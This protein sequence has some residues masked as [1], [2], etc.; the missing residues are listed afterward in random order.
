MFC[1]ARP[2]SK[3]VGPLPDTIRATI[4]RAPRTLPGSKTASASRSRTAELSTTRKRHGC[5]FFAL[6]ASRPASRILRSD[7]G[8]MGLW[9]YRRVSRRE[10]IASSVSTAAINSADFQE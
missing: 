3:E 9:S 4:R 2:A 6:P 5:L 10:V 1:A 8:G 7:S